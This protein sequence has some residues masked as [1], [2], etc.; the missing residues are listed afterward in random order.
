M[1]EHGRAKAPQW[2]SDGLGSASRCWRPPPRSQ[3]ALQQQ[4][5]NKHDNM[6]L[7]VTT[8][9]HPRSFRQRKPLPK[10]RAGRELL[11]FSRLPS[12]KPQKTRFGSQKKPGLGPKK[13]GLGR[14]PAGPPGGS[15]RGWEEVAGR[16]AVGGVALLG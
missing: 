4:K 7:S 11:G 10:G 6:T 12:P 16:W 8:H 13:P 14:A 2:S 15:R 3:A 9:S 5:A 1:R